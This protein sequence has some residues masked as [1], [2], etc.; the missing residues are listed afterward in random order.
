MIMATKISSI[1]HPN[2]KNFVGHIWDHRDSSGYM[3][4]TTCI[5]IPW[6]ADQY[7]SGAN[8][9]SM[10]WWIHDHLPY[11][12]LYSFPKLAAFNLNWHENPERLIDSYIP[13]K[14]CLTKPGMENHQG[15]H[16]EFYRGFPNLVKPV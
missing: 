4:A 16:S 14:G 13:P 11:S 9:R 2:E 1:A 10:A 8:W 7:E 5:V 12:S 3:G 6:F 15:D